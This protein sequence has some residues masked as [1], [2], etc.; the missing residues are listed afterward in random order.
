MFKTK[1]LKQSKPNVAVKPNNSPAKL[2]I[3]PNTVLTEDKISERA[4]EL[5]ESRGREP[6]Q[7][8]QDW[9]GAEQEILKR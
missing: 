9:F 7:D 1:A 2:A 6:G 4:Y 5:Y 8:R 3:M